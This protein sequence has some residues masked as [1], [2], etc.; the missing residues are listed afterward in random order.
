MFQDS[1]CQFVELVDQID[2]RVD[3]EQV[4]VRDFLTV[5][6]V[7]H[8]IEFAIELGNL[9]RVF[10]VAQVHRIIHGSTEMRALAVVEIIEDCRIIA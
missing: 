3:I 10:T 6:L 4:V 5:Q 8:I 2:G 1:K 9:V 7:K